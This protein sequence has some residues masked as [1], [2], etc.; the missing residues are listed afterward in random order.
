MWETKKVVYFT[1][2]PRRPLHPI[3]TKIGKVS[4]TDE[5]TKRAKYDVDQLIGAGSVGS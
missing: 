3:V 2:L 4:D 5:I 1:T